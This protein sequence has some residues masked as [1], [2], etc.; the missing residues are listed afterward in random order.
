MYK[1]K[2]YVIG[3]PKVRIVGKLVVDNDLEL[4]TPAKSFS[5]ENAVSGSLSVTGDAEFQ[6]CQVAEDVVVQGS[7]TAGE[8]LFVDDIDVAK[9][10]DY[11]TISSGPMGQD[12]WY[13]NDKALFGLVNL[14]SSRFEGSFYDTCN[15]GKNFVFP[16]VGGEENTQ[17]IRCLSSGKYELEWSG[18]YNNNGANGNRIEFLVVYGPT[19]G[20]TD[21]SFRTYVYALNLLDSSPSLYYYQ[22]HFKT[23]VYLEE[24][25]EYRFYARPKNATNATSRVNYIVPFTITLKKIS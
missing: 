21:I 14:R 8:Q 10:L 3:G 17:Q 13:E 23:P 22:F 1:N 5:T 11:L 6:S 25:K 9:R 4:A 18:L 7:L 20:V 24:G 15:L 19:F 16:V 12:S 2:E